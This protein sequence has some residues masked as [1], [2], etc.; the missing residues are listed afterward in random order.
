MEPTRASLW[1]RLSERAHSYGRN[2]L[3]IGQDWPQDRLQD[4]YAWTEG[5]G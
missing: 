5:F 4:V 1:A 3:G 2:A